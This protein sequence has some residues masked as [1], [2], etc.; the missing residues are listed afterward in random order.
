MSVSR[1]RTPKSAVEADGLSASSMLR[2]ALGYDALTEPADITL[3]ASPYVAEVSHD[4]DA[5]QLTADWAQLEADGGASVFQAHSWLRGLIKHLVPASGATPIFVTLREARNNRA[6][7]IFP[8]Q[9]RTTRGLKL[10]E[11]LASD[12]CDTCQPLL[13]LHLSATTDA[14]DVLID[15]LVA[16]LPPADLL[17]LE[18]MQRDL[19]GR[20][21]PFNDRPGSGCSP[22]ATFPVDLRPDG[23]AFVGATSA[24]K[25]YQKQ[26]RKLTRRE[27]IAFEIFETSEAIAAAFDAMIAMRNTRF[28]DLNRD[29]L[30]NDPKV[31][32]FYRD[33]ALLPAAERAA[34]ITG[35]KVGDDYKAYIYMM[36]RGG[37]FS[38]VISAID[39]TVGNAYAPGLILFTKIFEHAIETGYLHGDIGIGFM[40]YKTRFA[41][42]SNPLFMW[43][44]AL[45]WRGHLMLAGL[46]AAR[47]TKDWA[48]ENRTV[49]AVAE[50]VLKRR[51]GGPAVA[52]KVEAAEED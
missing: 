48:R 50:K 44:R 20:P 31:A 35:L 21:N 26:W 29:D 45:S 7:A 40:P 49:R 6:V 52:A 12:F 28:T 15:A 23:A 19:F 4:I 36:D 9:Q 24:Y 2:Y 43:E 30:L 10:V 13:S 14:A 18:K 51:I 1:F 37:K 41:P 34:R 33:M 16:A 17:R 5:S 42:A 3:P 8:L 46:N 38:T 39:N 11:Y 25:A 22:H 27:G 32:K 47:A